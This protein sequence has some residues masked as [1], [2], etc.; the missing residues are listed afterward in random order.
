MKE[1]LYLKLFAVSQIGAL[2]GE[3][4]NPV[5]TQRFLIVGTAVVYL[6]DWLTGIAASIKAGRKFSSRRM[7]EAIPK[8]IGY[9][10]VVILVAVLGVVFKMGGMPIPEWLPSTVVGGVLALILV[11]ESVSVLE[12]I[13]ELAPKLKRGIVKRIFDG[14]NDYLNEDEP[15]KPEV[16]PQP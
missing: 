14:L 9:V 4:V 5:A 8:L 7:R 3:F 13:F 12:N 6:L 15:A 11:I 2:I 1:N 16:S 10:A